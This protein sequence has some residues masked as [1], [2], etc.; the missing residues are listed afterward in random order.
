M[1][2][3]PKTPTLDRRNAVIGESHAI[4]RFLDWLS[5]EGIRLGRYERVEGLRGEW[6]LQIHEGPSNLLH[7]YFNIDPAEEERELRAILAAQTESDGHPRP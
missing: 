1:G 4:G 5:E 7:R 3:Y 2:Q 6:L